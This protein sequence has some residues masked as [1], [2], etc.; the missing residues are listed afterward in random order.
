MST[1]P[2][3]PETAVVQVRLPIHHQPTVLRTAAGCLAFLGL[4]PAVAAGLLVWARS[5]DPVARWVAPA[6]GVLAV[7]CF[8]S[9]PIMRWYIRRHGSLVTAR[10]EFGPDGFRQPLEDKTTLVLPWDDVRR[11]DFRGGQPGGRVALAVSLVAEEAMKNLNPDCRHKSED[12]FILS[13]A[14]A[15]E[16]AEKASAAIERYRPGLVRWTSKNV[17]RGGFGV[18]NPVK[19]LVRRW[20]A[21]QVRTLVRA[22]QA[23]GGRLLVLWAAWLAVIADFVAPAF[24]DIPPGIPLPVVV[25]IWVLL[26]LTRYRGQTGKFVLAA[27][28]I[29][30]QPEEGEPIRVRRADLARLT[31]EPSAKKATRQYVSVHAILRRGEERQLAV[32]I[33][34][35]A[36]KNV[37]ARGG[38][39]PPTPITRGAT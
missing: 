5:H 8:C 31:A 21:D 18:P 37:I 6:L 9:G 14:M 26:Y 34:P 23:S 33:S 22:E 19:L 38:G 39:A 1:T 15:P 36:A 32:K 11:F 28:A 10:V 7:L 27:D 13:S 12:G 29:T 2:G 17:R 24:F 20:S 25:A 35:G 4:A 3:E 16:E 30:W